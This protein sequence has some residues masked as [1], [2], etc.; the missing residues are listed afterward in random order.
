MIFNKKEI[1]MEFEYI[2]ASNQIK[3]YRLLAL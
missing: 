2:R 3:A 1:K